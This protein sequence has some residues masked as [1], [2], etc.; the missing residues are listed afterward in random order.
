MAIALAL[1]VAVWLI[2]IPKPVPDT[3]S[4]I[5][6]TEQF[7]KWDFTAYEAR[8]TPGYSILLLT[9]GLSPQIVWILQ[10][11]AGVGIGSFIFYIAFA[12]TSSVSFSF[13]CGLSYHFN[14]GQLFFEAYL[15]P[16]TQTTFLLIGTLAGLVLMFRRL[17]DRRLVAGIALFVG[18]FAG[19]TVMARPQ[20]VFLPILCGALVGFV[21]RVIGRL[22]WRLVVTYAAIALIPGI[23]MILGWC[24]F[25]YYQ[26]G[27]FTLSSHTGVGL[28]EHTI[29]FAELAPPKYKPLADILVK[30]RDRHLAETGRHTATWDAVPELKAI[31]GLPLVRLD[32]ELTKMSLELILKNPF[33]YL[34]L[35]ADAWTSF[36][37][38]STPLTMR[39]VQPDH[40]RNLLISTW[41]VEQTVLRAINGIFLIIVAIALFSKE[42]RRTAQW[43]LIHWTISMLVLTSCFLQALVIGVDNARYGVT[44]QALIVLI[45]LTVSYCLLEDRV[46]RHVPVGVYTS[47]GRGNTWL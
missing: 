38:V 43:G 30:Y 21:C 8:R 28:M 22:R 44:V 46:A 39:D 11:L 34:V 16:E 13:L 10:M 4:Y 47:K 27:R 15:I 1:R 14:L 37:L 2:A 33:R 17:E 9:G 24:S 3:Q 6:L 23:L 32:A 29:A 45:V 12:L 20:F 41:A 31:T 35:V 7:L 36:W 42:F 25:N 40:L 19:V 18:V 5:D 26:V